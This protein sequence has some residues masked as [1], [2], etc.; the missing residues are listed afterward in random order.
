[1]HACQR[2]REGRRGE[3][4]WQRLLSEEEC[5]LG[6]LSLYFC[7]S[8]AGRNL[9]GGLRGGFQQN[10]H[11]FFR[12]AVSGSRSPLIGQC[13]SRGSLVIA[14]GAVVVHLILLLFWAWNWNTTGAWILSLRGW[15]SA[16][17]CKWLCQFVQL[18]VLVSLFYLSWVV[19]LS[20]FIYT[21]TGLACL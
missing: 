12:C 21:F 1:M 16:S 5:R 4:E 17:G 13:Q 9:R 10:T 11:P 20:H 15:P 7:L 2:R 8:L 3:R 14:A 18:S 6:F 19:V